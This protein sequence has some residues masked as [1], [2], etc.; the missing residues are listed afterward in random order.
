M[1]EIK[2][3]KKSKYD[4]NWYADKYQSL[5]VWRNWLVLITLCSIVAVLFMTF[6]QLY[7]LPLKTVKPFVIQ[8]DDKT[9]LTQVV[10]NDVVQ[11]YNANQELI[12]HFAM[13]Y[14]FARENYNY[15]LVEEMYKKVRVL[16][17]RKLYASF[18]EEVNPTNPSSPIARFNT[19][20]LRTVQLQSY[21]LQNPNKSPKE[22][23]IVQVRLIVT[24]AN[25]NTMPERYT[26]QVTMSCGFKRDLPLTEDDRLI[27]PLGF[28]VLSYSVDSFREAA[29]LR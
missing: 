13:S 12:K 2:P 20:T 21:T 18:R 22:D 3:Q 25:A 15:L 5:I 27:N 6:S 26:V 16:S 24:E 23:S 17:D 14:I 29:P 11:D 28:Q 19:N 7:L 9:G 8:I 1:N 4:V 10:T